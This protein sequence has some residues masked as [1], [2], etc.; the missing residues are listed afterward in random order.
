MFDPSGNFAVPKLSLHGIYIPNGCKNFKVLLF[1]NCLMGMKQ[2]LI[3]HEKLEKWKKSKIRPRYDKKE[4]KRKN[5][6][7]K[8]E[9][10]LNKSKNKKREIKVQIEKET[11][12][13]I[14][15]GK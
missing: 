13:Q 4:Y 14:E 11:K 5:G 1:Y 6:M 15:K 10:E 8:I 12:V 7:K 2:T 3:S 9:K